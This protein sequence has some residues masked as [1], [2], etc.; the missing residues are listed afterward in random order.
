MSDS[1]SAKPAIAATAGVVV[2]SPLLLALL[3]LAGAVVF[4][5]FV[6]LIAGIPPL[7]TYQLVLTG[8]FSS[9]ATRSD[10]LMLAAPLLL[11]A[12]GLTISFAAGLYNLG[13][14]G[15]ITVGAIFCLGIMRALPDLSPPLLWALALAAGMVG[16]VAWALIAALLRRYG[17]VSEIFAGLGLNFLATGLVLYLI[18]GPWKKPGTASITGTEQLPRE[19]W[20][21]TLEGLRLAPLA[22]LLA[23]LALVIV[24]I[25]LERTRWGL[26]VRAAG[27]NPA[28]A[29]RLG[30]PMTRRMFE[31]FAACGALAGL[32]GGLQV[33]AVFHALI[34]NVSSGIGLLALLVVL[35]VNARPAWVLPVVLL[36]A[37][38]AIGALKLPLTLGADSSL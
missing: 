16:G 20:L 7:D 5:T 10:T 6:L 9:P 18:A 14:E 17:R 24:W 37:A 38:F 1:V 3:A 21:P 13:V 19:G 2:R 31:A 22:P 26:E 33:L 34:S 4:T 15:Q 29:E 8:W 36:F 12:A 23:L 27:T 32:A 11:C 30:I 35:L 25:V 28:A